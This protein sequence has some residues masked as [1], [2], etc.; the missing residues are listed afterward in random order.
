MSG[1]L[2]LSFGLTLK[3][4]PKDLP[5]ASISI[6]FGFIMKKTLAELGS[7]LW[8]KWANDLYIDDKKIG[9]VLTSK[10]G[11]NLICGIGINL[12]YAPDEFTTLDINID[13]DIIL[14]N[15]FNIIYNKVL[16]KKIF[17]EYKKEFEKSKSLTFTY[18]NK[19]ISL[20]S[21]I[22]NS[23]GSIKIGKETIYS[24]R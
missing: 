6:Y 13:R 14:K 7:K 16:W 1:N 19:K 5:L 11:N 10:I 9:G 22:L 18:K 4:L 20:K 21:A 12:K 2:F 8:L 3:D 15:F 17:L 24:L 23:D